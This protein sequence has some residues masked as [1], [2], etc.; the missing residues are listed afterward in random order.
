MSTMKKTVVLVHGAWHGG[1]CWRRV[2]D[3]LRSQGHRVYTPTLTGLGERSHL[4][5]AGIDV[6]THITD[7]VNLFKWEE[8]SDVILC[9]HSYGGLVISGVA[10]VIAPSIGGMVFVDAFVPENGDSMWNLTSDAVR[11]VIKGATDRGEIA[12]PPRP[13]SVFVTAKQDQELVDRLCT[14]QP[15]GT[16]SEKLKLTGAYKRIAS[17]TYIRAKAYINPGFDTALERA[18]QDG[19]WRVHELQCAHDIMLDMPDKLAEI[20]AAA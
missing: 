18:R 17:K 20:I 13:A 3:L 16:S 15:I 10:E 7:I 4:L 12:M 6:T 1:W 8:L 2:A 19:T 14:P 11:A 5:R 9:G